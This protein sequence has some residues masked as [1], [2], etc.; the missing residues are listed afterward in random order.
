M[1]S[2]SSE[3]TLETLRQAAKRIEGKVRY[4][5]TVELEGLLNPLPGAPELTLKL[6]NLQPTGSFKVRGAVNTVL[7]LPEEQVKRGLITASGGNHGLAVT[8]AARIAGTKAV[9]YLPEIAPP[10]K[11]EKL[12]AWG[13]EVVIEG[14][15]YNDTLKATAARAEQDGLTNVHAFAPASV[16]N[17]Q[18]TLG[19]ELVEQ[20]KRIDT[21]IVAVGGGGLI[22]G[23]AT[24]V[25]ALSPSTRIIGVEPV[26]A[27]THFESRKLG[28]LAKLEAITTKASSLAPSRTERLNFDLVSAHVDELV[29]VSDEE[30]K[31]AAKWLW[32]EC[33]QAV[34][35]AAAATIACLQNGSVSLSSG[36][37]VTAI[38]CG[39]GIDGL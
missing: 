13:A 23:V 30:M 10:D 20:I 25:K 36:E 26:G 15:V 37:N 3:V 14:A 17:G 12:R 34:E 32:F 35:M 11:A 8:Y 19:L 2:P 18:G 1:S 21:L 22:S 16:I 6:D 4:T 31:A 24:A 29:L 28:D 5:P 33:G 39:A 7:S 27:P 9:V 38:M